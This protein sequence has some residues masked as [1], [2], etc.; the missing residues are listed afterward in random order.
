MVG[1]AATSDRVVGCCCQ[2]GGTSRGRGMIVGMK[3]EQHDT[4]GMLERTGYTKGE[5]LL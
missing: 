2:G 4:A 1:S 3:V 5:P